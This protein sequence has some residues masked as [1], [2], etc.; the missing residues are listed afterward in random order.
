MT[1]YLPGPLL[2]LFKPRETPVWKDE[3]AAAAAAAEGDGA[4]AEQKV[5]QAIEIAPSH[6][7]KYVRPMKGISEYTVFFETAA[8]MTP[9]TRGDTKEEREVKKLAAREERLTTQM[10]ED[11]AAWDPYNDNNASGDAFKTLFVGRLAFDCTESQLR[12][13]F[14]AYGPI[15]HCRVVTDS[16]TG[17]SR[18]YAFVEY[19]HES[20]LKDAYKQA[21]GKKVEGK[22]IVVDVERGRTVKSWLPRKLGGGK[23][24]SRLGPPHVCV[25]TSGRD[26]PG[27][28]GSSSSRSGGGGSSGGYGGGYSGRSESSSSRGG[29]YGGGSSYRRDSRGG[30]GGGGGRDDYRDRDRRSGRDERGGGD[31]DRRDSN[32]DRD[33]DRDRRGDRRERSRSRDRDRSRRSSRDERGSGSA[34]AGPPAAMAP[35]SGAPP[36]AMAP[37]G[38]PP[39]AGMGP[40]PAGPP[41]GDIGPP[42]SGPP[43]Q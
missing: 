23:G 18:G 6:D 16:K 34:D 13:E 35:P 30:S 8:E 12:R 17:K 29:G 3:A 31:R 21:D 32:R 22:R 24:K 28:G 33:R 39:P 42:P 1:A 4:Q 40:P 27:G 43:P 11:K 36:A 5:N 25:K 26:E 9:A 41:P 20:D 38:G 14:E 15:A 19:E 10:G 7:K 37:P 2:A